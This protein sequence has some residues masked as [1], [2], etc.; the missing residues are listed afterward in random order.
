MRSL[1]CDNSM[2]RFNVMCVSSQLSV[3]FVIANSVGVR[4][5]VFRFDKAWFPLIQTIIS[6]PDRMVG[7]VFYF[8]LC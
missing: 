4:C 2:A 7:L 8:L 6:E 1:L 3:T 5:T